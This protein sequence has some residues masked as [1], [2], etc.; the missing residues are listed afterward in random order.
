MSTLISICITRFLPTSN[1]IIVKMRGTSTQVR[2][3][4]TAMFYVIKDMD[5]SLEDKVLF[6]GLLCFLLLGSGCI[7][8]NCFEDKITVYY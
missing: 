2:D 3:R 7:L 5:A 1:G 4:V 8:V 6:Y